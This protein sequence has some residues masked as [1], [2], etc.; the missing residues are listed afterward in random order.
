MGECAA[1]GT[2]TAG[3]DSCAPGPPTSEVCDNL[4]NNCDGTIDE[5]FGQTTCGLGVCEITVDD[6]VG[7]VPQTCT[8]GAPT[9]E[10]C[11]G[12]DDDCDGAVD[13]PA[14]SCP[15]TVPPTMT[16]EHGTGSSLVF[17]WE[18]SC[19][20]AAQDYGIY[21]GELDNWYSHTQIDCSDDLDDRIEEIIPSPGNR[22]YLIVPSRTSKEGSYGR[23]SMNFERP[24]G[25]STCG[26]TQALGEC[27]P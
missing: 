17:H 16:V 5:G 22:Y 6:C 24:Q 3:V 20:A 27:S 25:A 26:G 1:T 10:T 18:A 23:D 14:A 8:P 2:C 13:G 12:I 15:G 19:S 11:N 21:E 7:G 9:A 4:D